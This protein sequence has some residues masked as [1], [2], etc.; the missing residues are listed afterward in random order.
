[1][2]QLISIAR[3]AL[4]YSCHWPVSRSDDGKA[5]HVAVG[6]ECVANAMSPGAP[7]HRGEHS[8]LGVRRCVI[9]PRTVPDSG[10]VNGDDVRLRDA[11]LAA[12]REN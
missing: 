12:A 9:T 1:M 7:C 10:G 11:V 6:V 8:H 5:Q 2:T 4:P 3:K